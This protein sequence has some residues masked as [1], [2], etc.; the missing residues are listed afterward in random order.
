MIELR[1]LNGRFPIFNLLLFLEL[2]LTDLGYKHLVGVR[3]GVSN[4]V[5]ANCKSLFNKV[6][7]F[8]LVLILLLGVAFDRVDLKGLIESFL[9]IELVN[10]LLGSEKKLFLLVFLYKDIDVDLLTE[11]DRV[12]TV[13]K[14]EEA[15][16]KTWLSWA[17]DLLSKGEVLEWLDGNRADVMLVE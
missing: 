5:A 14:S 7:D 15:A 1:D 16:V 11:L 6:R 17:S 3:V 2:K 4:K 10:H 8:F 13:S 12:W 9:L